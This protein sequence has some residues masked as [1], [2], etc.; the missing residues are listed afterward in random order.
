MRR[1]LGF[2]SALIVLA[3]VYF[4]WGGTWR[5][6]GYKPVSNSAFADIDAG[7]DYPDVEKLLGTPGRLVSTRGEGEGEVK[8]YEWDTEDGKQRRIIFRAG[9]VVALSAP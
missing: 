9:K 8:A 7:L 5:D 3:F 1:K 4:V 2:A 6:E